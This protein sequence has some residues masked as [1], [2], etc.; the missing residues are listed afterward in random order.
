MLRIGKEASRKTDRHDRNGPFLTPELSNFQLQTW[1]SIA[2]LSAHLATPRMSRSQSLLS[3]NGEKGEG[4]LPREYALTLGGEE[5]ADFL[6]RTDIGT[7]RH[8]T[9]IGTCR[10]S[11]PA[12]AGYYTRQPDS[13]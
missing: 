9:D 3:T 7:C 1:G 12:H 10:H 11:L 2:G 13:M 5:V 8:S 4:G 6:A